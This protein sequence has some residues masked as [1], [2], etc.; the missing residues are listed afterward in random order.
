MASFVFLKAKAGFANK[1]YDWDTD[2]FRA[3]PVDTVPNPDTDDFV[4]DVSPEEV[5][6]V[7]VSLASKAI[8]EDTAND[9]VELDCADFVFTAPN[10]GTMVGIVIY[11]QTGGDDTTPTNDG[12]IAFL[13][14]SD[15]VTNGGDVN[16]TVHAEGILKF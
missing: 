5:G 9:Q 6:S 14:T 4:D 10:D 12:L 2:V 7:R 1:L 3:M 16:V 15:I 8:V 13:D 11:Q